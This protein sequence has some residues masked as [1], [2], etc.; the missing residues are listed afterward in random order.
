MIEAPLARADPVASSQH[1]SATGTCSIRG[2]LAPP[3]SP[4]MLRL[5]IPNPHSSA[6]PWGKFRLQPHPQQH[7]LH[8]AQPSGEEPVPGRDLGFPN[9]AWQRGK[10]RA[11]SGTARA[12]KADGT[13]NCNPAPR[14]VSTF[15]ASHSSKLTWC[16]LSC[17]AAFHQPDFSLDCPL[18]RS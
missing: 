11:A 8:T 1:P 5:R 6:A 12:V 4:V 9:P 17:P 13:A 18:E 16:H 10:A 14:G 2:P 15:P 3:M 7:P